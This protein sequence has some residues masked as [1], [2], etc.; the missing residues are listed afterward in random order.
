MNRQQAFQIIADELHILQ[1]AQSLELAPMREETLALRS[2]ANV[3]KDIFLRVRKI[4]WRQT[5]SSKRSALLKND[6][7]FILAK[8]FAFTADVVYRSHGT[9]YRAL[10]D[11]YAADLNGWYEYDADESFSDNVILLQMSDLFFKNNEN[12]MSRTLEGN[13]LTGFVVYNL[14]TYRL[15]FETV[16]GFRSESG[17]IYI[18]P[19]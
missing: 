4:S 11:Y 5:L 13:R 10:R 16:D 18:L 9:H 3:V 15:E 19:N 14:K 17:S 1:S 6:N 12:T 8:S 7:C 2:W